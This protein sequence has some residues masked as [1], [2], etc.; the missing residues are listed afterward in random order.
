MVG[1]SP[2]TIGRD[3]QEH[4]AIRATGASTLPT[5][6][7]VPRRAC[8]AAA[9]AATR[10][11]ARRARAG[12]RPGEGDSCGYGSCCTTG[13]PA[14]SGGARCHCARSL[15]FGTGSSIRLLPRSRL[16][17]RTPPAG[18]R[19]PCY[20]TRGAWRARAAR[21]RPMQWRHSPCLRRSLP[22]PAYHITP[23]WCSGPLTERGGRPARA[24]RPLRRR[25]HPRWRRRPLRL[26]RSTFPPR[27]LQSDRTG[28]RGAAPRAVAAVTTT[29]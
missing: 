3:G 13:T 6:P 29:C 21:F 4:L 15:T 14:P 16:N 20:Y 9:L 24:R 26:Q 2:Q 18:L 27:V 22:R 28:R 25:R 10:R 5:A 8:A 1:G 12:P 7:H 17:A 11:P 23:A 19:Q